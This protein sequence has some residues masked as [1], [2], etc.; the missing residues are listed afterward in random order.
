MKTSYRV[1]SVG[2]V[3][4]EPFLRV[5]SAYVVRSH[6]LRRKKVEL[7]YIRTEQH[8]LECFS[9]LYRLYA[10]LRCQ[11]RIAGICRWNSFIEGR[12]ASLVCYLVTSA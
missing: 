3:L 11:S 10:F 12:F 7:A 8:I 9:I 4:W 1:A 2:I 6:V 5:P